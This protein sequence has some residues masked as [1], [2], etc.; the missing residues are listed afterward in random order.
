MTPS[1]EEL[2][3][4]DQN[5]ELIKKLE[6][7]NKDNVMLMQLIKKGE[8]D[9]SQQLKSQSGR[10]LSSQNTNNNTMAPKLNKTTKPIKKKQTSSM[11][12]EGKLAKEIKNEKERT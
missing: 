9:S 11:T 5:D 6:K 3:L 7:A 4:K 8:K 2:N 12:G 1:Q 10:G